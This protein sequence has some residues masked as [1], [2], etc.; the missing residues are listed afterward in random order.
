MLFILILFVIL[1][2]AIVFGTR[3]WTQSDALEQHGIKELTD[4]YYNTTHAYV[5]KEGKP[6]FF[7]HTPRSLEKI[8]KYK[9]QMNT[10]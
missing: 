1:C 5:T 10:D 6:I 7:P 3:F 2:V 9:Q 4:V 8:K